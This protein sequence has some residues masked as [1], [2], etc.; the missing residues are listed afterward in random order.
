MN[1]SWA[2]VGILFRDQNQI[3]FPLGRPFGI[4]GPS[5][6]VVQNYIESVEYWELKIEEL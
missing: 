3:E 1:F 4:D 6:K 2:Q 5:H